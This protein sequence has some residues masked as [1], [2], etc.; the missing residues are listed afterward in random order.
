MNRRQHLRSLGLSALGATLAP[1]VLA[2]QTDTKPATPMPA[3]G[4]VLNE[5]LRF[6]DSITGRPV[7]QLTSKRDFNQKPTY[8]IGSGFSADS[9]LLPVVSWNADQSSC[10]MLANLETGELKVLDVTE[11]GA[12]FSY[13]KAGNDMSMLPK[14]G[15]VVAG[16]SARMLKLFDLKT[17]KAEVLL[18]DVGKDFTLG[19]PIGSIDGKSVYVPKMKTIPPDTKDF[20]PY[21]SVEYLEIN[22]SSG[23]TRTV[24]TD[25][26]HRNNHMMPNPQNPDLWLIDRD[27]PP[28]FGRGS[29]GGKTTRS[30]ILNIKTGA[31]T[32]VR[33]NAANRFQVH[34]NWNFDGTHV[35]YHGLAQLP[36]KRENPRSF[37]GN[38]H[39][40]GVADLQGKIVWE[41]NFPH[42]WYGHVSSHERENTIVLDGL[43]TENQLTGIHWN[44]RDTLN[45]PAISLYGTHRSDWANIGQHA[46][47]HCQVSP[48]GRWLS[49]NRSYEGRSDVYA[50][51]L[52]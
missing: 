2:Q 22:I 14:A 30:W 46:H 12:E 15:K 41:K 39:Y 23:K 20:A 38:T 49:Y 47:P 25:N 42:S 48:D 45:E 52:G 50:L 37:N 5:S 18:P 28:G 1:A 26:G 31:L 32:E 44:K 4:D 24:F 13:F 8:H 3:I 16:L 36:D 40:I 51:R 34:G 27:L 9:R 33:P 10:L 29:D 6:A 35:Y 43:I 19:H 11:A 7:I 21:C 17:G